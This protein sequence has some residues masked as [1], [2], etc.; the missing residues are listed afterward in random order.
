MASGLTLMLAPPAS[1]TIHCVGPVEPLTPR[2]APSL[3]DGDDP[4]LLGAAAAIARRLDVAPIAVRVAFVVLAVA[5]G[6]GLLLYLG[7]WLCVVRRSPRPERPWPSVADAPLRTVGVLSTMIGA[8]LMLRAQA[9]GFADTLVW[10][11]A[12]VGIGLV[13]GRH[14]L[15]PTVGRGR[16]SRPTARGHA[17]GAGRLTDPARLVGGFILVVGGFAS[18]LATNLTVDRLRDGLV[19]IAV[20]AAGVLLILGPWVVQLTR[21]LAEERSQRIRA[22]ERAEVAAHLH[23]SV[24]QT[25]TLLQKRS[26]DPQMMA[27]LARHQER[28][29]RRWLYGAPGPGAEARSFREAIEAMVSEV[30]DQHLVHVNNVIVGDGPLDTALRNLVAAAR[31][32][33]VN[34]A[35]FSGLRSLSLYGELLPSHAALYVRDRGVGFRLDE[36]APDR[37]GLSDSIVGRLRR[38]G[39]TAEIRSSPGR[40]TEV[41]LRL[42]R[43][44]AQPTPGPVRRA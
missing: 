8:L 38:L 12:V 5:G 14:K 35:K 44:V 6:W 41:R 32:A 11:V 22:D 10:P 1:A 42:D 27:A 7:L 43:P 29:L 20:V 18:L 28:E 40:G 30:E 17:H 19:A 9:V 16:S 3:L 26:D 21:S 39:G 34:A 36:V 4:L 2:A 13:V 25:L 15:A 33:L 31:E 37:K 23:D 24:L